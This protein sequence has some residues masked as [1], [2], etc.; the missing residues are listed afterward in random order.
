LKQAENL[1]TQLYKST[2]Q[3]HLELLCAGLILQS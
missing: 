2:V 1:I 3:P